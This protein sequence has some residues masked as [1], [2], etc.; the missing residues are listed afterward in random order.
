MFKVRG[1]RLVLVLADGSEW[2][3][4]PSGALS[5]DADWQF[6]EG[7]RFEKPADSGDIRLGD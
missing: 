2:S 6:Y 3:G 7:R 4:N 5:S 1:L